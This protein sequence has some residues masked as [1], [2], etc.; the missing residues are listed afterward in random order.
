MTIHPH[1]PTNWDP[2]RLLTVQDVAQWAQVHPKSVY[3]WIK[4]GRLYAIQLGPRTYRVP[5]SAVAEFLKEA[6]YDHLPPPAELIR[7][8]SAGERQ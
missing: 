2:T 6:G 1:V 8:G 7:E 3:R 5:A 4:T